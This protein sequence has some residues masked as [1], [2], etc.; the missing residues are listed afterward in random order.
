MAVIIFLLSEV[1]LQTQ[2]LAM[3]W[4]VALRKAFPEGYGGGRT[5]ESH[6]YVAKGLLLVAVTTLVLFFASGLYEEKIAYANRYVPHANRALRSF[7]MYLNVRHRSLRSRLS[8]DPLS[9]LF[10]RKSDEDISPPQS[11]FSDRRRKRGTSVPIPPIPPTNNPRGEL[12]F[13]S[14]VDR[15][16][17]ESYERYRAAFERKREARE[18]FAAAQTWWGWRVWPWNWAVESHSWFLKQTQGR[19]R[20]KQEWDT[21]KRYSSSTVAR[22][23][24]DRKFQLSPVWRR[25]LWVTELGHR[26]SLLYV[27]LH[28]ML[29]CAETEFITAAD[30]SALT[31]LLERHAGRIE[32][33]VGSVHHVNEIPIDFDRP[34][35]ERAQ[36]SLRTNADTSL[37]ISSTTL[38]FDRYLDSQYELLVKLRP[39]V[40]GHLD[41]CRLYTPEIDFR[42]FPSALGKLKRNISYACSYGAIFEF[43]AAAFRKG[44]ETAYPGRDVVEFVLQCEGRFTMSDDSHGPHAV[45]L[46]Y[47]RL[48]NYLRDVGIKDLWYLERGDSVNP[49]IGGR[50]M[51]AAKLEG[52]WWLNEFWREKGVLT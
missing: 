2:F 43:N 6:H 25:E 50:Q 1:F 31:A 45:G 8:V 44:W 46:N 28:N 37:G 35:F 41:L 7:N 14:R 49:G 10:R 9:H 42:D 26:F 23:D 24:E 34:T 29:R 27:I 38:L 30:V 17:R 33:L 18:L 16:F 5:V 20:G 12:I 3:P 51:R 15:N 52:D 21:A 22:W 48:Y 11:P 40:I 47:D 4:N 32:Y 13:S 39:E 19:N 36:N